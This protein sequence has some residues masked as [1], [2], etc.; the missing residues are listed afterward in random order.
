MARPHRRE[1]AKRID[2]ARVGEAGELLALVAAGF[3]VPD[4]NLAGHASEAKGFRTT[5]ASPAK[6][7]V[8]GVGAQGEE[9]NFVVDHHPGAVSADGFAGLILPG[10]AKSAEAI[11][12][13]QDARLLVKAFLDANK[14]ICA[15]GDGV[16][17]LAAMS[18]TSGVEG[19]AA[20]AMSGQVFA[21]GGET[22]REDAI[23]AFVSAAEAETPA[24]A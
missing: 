9:M 5:I 16:S 20:L 17:V 2:L 21:G 4:L 15:M 10:G 6:A 23:G 11:L 3:S 7:L 24:A 1:H 12:A 22:A 14:P 8:S 18:E 13:H 19:E